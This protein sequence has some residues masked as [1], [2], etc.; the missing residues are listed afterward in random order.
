[1]SK[2]IKVLI[3]DDEAL[4]RQG[5][6]LTIDWEKYDMEVVSDEANGEKGWE[7]FLRHAP[8]VVITDIVMPGKDGVQLAKL[9]KD[10]NP[11]TKVL[12]LS[13]HRDFE[14]AQQFLQ[15]GASGY[16]LKTAFDDRQLEQ[17]LHAFRQEL[18]PMRADTGDRV[19]LTE[20]LDQQEWTPAAKWVNRLE[21]IPSSGGLYVGILRTPAEEADGGQWLLKKIGLSEPHICEQADDGFWNI[22]TGMDEWKSLSLRLRNQMLA[23]YD[24][25]LE[26]K[27]PI[28]NAPEA[29]R[30]IKRMYRSER[31]RQTYGLK[32]GNSSDS[33][34]KAIVYLDE[35]M[36]EGLHSDDVA[37]R[38]GLSRGHFSSLFHKVT[39]SSFISFLSSRRLSAARYYL[40]DTEVKPMDIPQK[41]GISDYKYFSRWFKKETGMTPTEFRTES[42]GKS[43]EAGPLA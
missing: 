6:K 40:R 9:V 15:I 28:D 38:V 20:W 2:K 12:V 39:G 10:K 35:H 1:M 36:A 32:Q 21:R 3:V 37:R 25:S 29:L 5:L 41:I 30:A 23:G 22:I 16:L 8:E 26:W 18:L 14:Y 33:I 17:Y 31:I 7:A 43:I 42:P 11:D 13:C 27:G 4:V 24:L 34:V 19:S